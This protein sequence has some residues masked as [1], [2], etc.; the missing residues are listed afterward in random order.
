MLHQTQEET[1]FDNREAESMAFGDDPDRGLSVRFRIEEKHNQL[2]SEGGV[3][4]F[5]RWKDSDNIARLKSQLDELGLEYK[6]V[7]NERD[8][9]IDIK[10]KGAGRPIYDAV[11]YVE[12]K[13]GD[14]L[15]IK[16]RPVSRRD[17][18]R[19]A[20]RY[21]AWKAGRSTGAIGLPL[22]QW[23]GITKGMMEELANHGVGTV[24]Q[25]ASMPDELLSRIGHVQ[26]LKQRAK[27]YLEQS[28]GLAPLTQ[29]RAENA[30][31]KAQL[32]A[33]QTQMSAF[34]A[35]NGKP[36]AAEE[37][38]VPATGTQRRRKEQRD[39][40]VRD[41]GAAGEGQGRQR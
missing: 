23:P 18:I 33:L 21:K 14:K 8:D 37:T 20:A 30:E 5:D 3:A 35:A 19:F 34:M 40:E 27:D 4:R 26:A 22:S 2:K 11:E 13:S 38:K 15:D 6:E 28:K 1:Y 9:T 7:L 31:L 29:M 41:E 12:I 32:D 24:E 17:K 25:L 36:E 16:D 10:V 39:G